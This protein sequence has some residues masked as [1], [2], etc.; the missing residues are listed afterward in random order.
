M[1]ALS[2]VVLSFVVGAIAKSRHLS[3]WAYFLASLILTPILGLLIALADIAFGKE[4]AEKR[5]IAKDLK[6][7][8]LKTCPH[9]AEIIKS[10]ALVCRFCGRD[11]FARTDENI[12]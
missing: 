7:G 10:E 12:T 5:R 1:M 4:R 2:W 9:C 11:L 3:F 6:K 8:I